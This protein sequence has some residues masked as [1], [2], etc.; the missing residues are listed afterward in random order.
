[1][2]PSGITSE[3]NCGPAEG[4]AAPNA[5]CIG[6][7]IRC[8]HKVHIGMHPVNRLHGSSLQHWGSSLAHAAPFH[9]HFLPATNASGVKSCLSVFAGEISIASIPLPFPALILADTVP[10]HPPNSFWRSAL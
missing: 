10:D 2:Y 3:W 7:N 5:I 1:M 9:C 4:D 8:N 6:K